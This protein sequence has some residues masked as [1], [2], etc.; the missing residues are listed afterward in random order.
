MPIK[1]IFFFGLITLLPQVLVAA[2][3]SFESTNK[4][5]ALLELYTSEGC[6]SCPPADRWL[7]S[8]EKEDGLWQSFIPIALHVDYWDYIGWKDRFAS[9]DYSARQRQYASEHSLKT[10]YTPGFVY[11]GKEWRNWFAKKSLGFPEGN[12]PGVLK[13][14]INDQQVSIEFMPTKF[15]HKK[16]EVNLALL[17]FDL[18]TE[19]K[20]GENRGKK[21]PHNFVVLA[22]N[23]ANLKANENQYM[24]QLDIPVSTIK[25]SRFGI[26]AWIN[27]SHNQMPLQTVGGWLP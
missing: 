3:V 20:A 12:M 1:S 6:S 8:L 26:V 19:V 21:L 14:E 7:S 5:I 23:Q 27:D 18:E 4:Q 2:T 9:S 22:V 25:A 24:T 16:L 17:G 11:N 10:V 13:L 15:S